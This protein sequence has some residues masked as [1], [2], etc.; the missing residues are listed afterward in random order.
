MAARIEGNHMTVEYRER[1][2]RTVRYSSHEA[3][4]RQQ[5]RV[6]DGFT[7]IAPRDKVQLWP[8]ARGLLV[9]RTG[10]EGTNLPGR[11]DQS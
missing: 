3:A 6:V 11:S 10:G 1:V 9:S 2:I 8:D 4:G 5:A 7:P